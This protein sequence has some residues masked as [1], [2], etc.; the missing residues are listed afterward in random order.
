[1]DCV[2]NH[3]CPCPFEVSIAILNH[4]ADFRLVQTNDCG[5]QPTFVSSVVNGK[6]V[7]FPIATARIAMHSPV[8]ARHEYRTWELDKWAVRSATRRWSGKLKLKLARQSA[9]QSEGRS[10]R[11]VV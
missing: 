7:R 8:F 6:V 11:L 4:I 2:H 9:W 10:S 3:C 5:H 1:M